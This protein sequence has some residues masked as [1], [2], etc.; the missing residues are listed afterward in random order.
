LLSWFK[1]LFAGPAEP[2]PPPPARPEPEAAAP[3][4]VRATYDN[5]AVTDE[6]SRHW[7]HT[8]ALSARRA[9]SPA[10]RKLLRER[11][12]YEVGNNSYAAG[13]VST[14]ANDLVGAG[15]ALAGPARGRRCERGRRGALER[16][17]AAVPHSPTN[18][19]PPRA[20]TVDGEGVGLLVNN[21]LSPCPVQL[22]VLLVETDQMADLFT[23][24]LD[25]FAA[26][27]LRFDEYGNVTE[28]HFL[29]HHP[30][31]WWISPLAVKRSRRGTCCTGSAATGPASPRRAGADA[32]A[33]PVR[34][35]PPVHPGDDRGR[36]DGRELRGHAA[37][38][39]A[40]QRR[41]EPP[42]PFDTLEIERGMMTQLPAGWDDGAAQ[43]RTPGDHV[44]NVRL[45]HPARNLPLFEPAPQRRPG[46]QQQEQLQPRPG[47][48]TSPTARTSR[49]SARTASA[50]GSS[51]SSPPGTRG[52]LVPGY[53]PP[54]LPADARALPHRVALAA[55]AS[56]RR[57]G[58]ADA[59][60]VR[61]RTGRR[62][63]R[64]S[65]A[66]RAAT[67]GRWCAR[68]E[69]VEVYREQVRRELGAPA[70]KTEGP[71]DGN[72]A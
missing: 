2:P 51:A 46:R 8:D 28:Y 40:R 54:G 35:A 22:D 6:N 47:S 43:G 62:R 23:D 27:G 12:R 3:A 38:A 1:A 60:E 33:R 67:G 55:V 30:G 31:D 24:P 21:P 70:P 65:P 71:G 44:R 61:L 7:T 50:S 11:S 42:D 66:S 36:G 63:C 9:N 16:V 49:S 57:K 72:A 17:G 34:P 13:I 4:R 18:S 26:D 45:V 59:D 29:P 48:T 10:V 39:G 69:Q 53:F 14:L 37:R 58:E 15:P 56:R 68:Q 5:A 25:L 52:P 64:S 41:R 20:K 32:G 19:G